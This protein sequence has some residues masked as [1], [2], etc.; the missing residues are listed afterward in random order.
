MLQRETI[1]CLLFMQQIAIAMDKHVII[2]FVGDSECL[3]SEE[4]DTKYNSITL[5]RSCSKCC[6]VLKEVLRIADRS[7]DTLK[8]PEV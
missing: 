3:R 6:S 5:H 8:M 2:I 1:R 7:Q 4:N